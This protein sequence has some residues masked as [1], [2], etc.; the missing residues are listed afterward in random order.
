M[1]NV[2]SSRRILHLQ[3]SLHLTTI[4]ALKRQSEVFQNEELHHRELVDIG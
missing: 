1:S 3:K 2:S 4:A